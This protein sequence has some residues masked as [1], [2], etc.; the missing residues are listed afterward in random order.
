MTYAM[1]DELQRGVREAAGATA[2]PCW[3][4]PAAGRVLRRHRPRRPR[5]TPLVPR[6]AAV[7][8]P[9]RPGVVAA[10][11]CPKPVDLRRRR[12]GRSAWAPS[13][14]RSATCA[15]RRR[16]RASHGIRAPRTGAR[17]RRRHVAAAPALGMPGGDEAADRG[18]DL[19]A[20][21]A[22]AAGTSRALVEPDLCPRGARDRP[23][24]TSSGRRSRSTSIKALA[25]EGL[26]RSVREHIGRPRRGP[27][28]VLPSRGTTPRAWRRSSSAAPPTSPAADDP[29][30]APSERLAASGVLR[31]GPHPHET[32]RMARKHS[33]G[34]SRGGAADADVGRHGRRRRRRGPRRVGRRAAR[35]TPTATRRRR[36][37]AAS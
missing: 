24:R 12:P 29:A 26:E 30:V 1:L 19:D 36:G 22:F 31:A 9:R 15:S 14:R 7:A 33:D 20:E 3:S 6:A 37:A 18:R 11:Q 35:S 28:G 4:S 34:V 2:P 13:A 17:H 5:A 25:Y 32:T 16:E 8:Q 10:V 21:E 27:V 23:S